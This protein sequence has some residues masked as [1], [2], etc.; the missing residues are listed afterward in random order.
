MTGSCPLPRDAS[1]EVITLAHGEGARVT[2]LWLEREIA[3]LLADGS[4]SLHRD[5]AR[6]TTSANLCFS[7]DSYVVT[8]RFFPGGD[9]GR[10]AV[11]G[12]ANDLA[13]SGARAR[14]M[15]L[16]L[17]LEEGLP[18]VEIRSVLE[19]IRAAAG[20]LAIAVVAGDTKVVPRGAADGLF[21]NTSGI[22]EL[23]WELPGCARLEAG[24]Q[25]LVSGPIGCHGF[26]ILNAREALGFDPPPVSDCGS[27]L[28]V[29]EALWNAGVQVRA[30]RD[31]T[32]GGVGAVLQEWASAGDVTIRVKKRQI[33]VTDVVQGMSELL[34]LDPIHVA[35]EGTMV[36][37]VAK[38]DV[39][40]AL[41]AMR[42]TG[43]GE[44]ATA[45]GEVLPRGL[46]PVV[47]RGRLDRDLPLDEPSG[48][49]LPRIC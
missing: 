5:A 9:I 26:A 8:P 21:L 22:G 38:S 25:L 12:T 39:E 2:R 40:R 32:R 7:T 49:P 34:G 29:V 42:R 20:E 10:L 16:S 47:I 46:T 11:I 27:L 14:W 36:V 41:E 37:A 19:S 35:C 3:P 48:A 6:L 1:G 33:P 30:M 45:I 4:V 13:V 24:D 43:R 31:A 23:F 44:Q 17:I 28:P 15:S 18:L